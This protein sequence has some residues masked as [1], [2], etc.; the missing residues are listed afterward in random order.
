MAGFN[1]IAKWVKDG[2]LMV[3]HIVSLKTCIRVGC[4]VNDDFYP[5][6]NF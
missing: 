2:V 3:I 6:G 1:K 5:V 4:W